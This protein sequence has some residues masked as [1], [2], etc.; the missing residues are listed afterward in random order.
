[1]KNNFNLIIF[2]AGFISA[3]FL[4]S[5]IKFGITFSFFLIFISIILFIFRKFISVDFENK[6]QIFFIAIFILSFA[7]GIFRYE[8]KDSKTLDINLENNIN[9]KVVIEG[10]VSD[11]PTIKDK[12]AIL[13]VGLKNIIASSS[14]IVVS[15]KGLVSTDLYPEIKYGD[16]IKIN[17]KLEKPENFINESASSSF[18][19]ISYLAKDDIFYKID[20]AKTE[21]ISSGN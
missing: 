1:M 15:G 20:F 6:K 18:D 4:S 17:G 5:F 16:L 2:V 11:E 10:I 12:Q 21:I 19:Y 9:E 3:I 8:L 13:T 7:L 14:K